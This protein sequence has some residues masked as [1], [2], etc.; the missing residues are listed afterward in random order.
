MYATFRDVNKFIELD[1]EKLLERLQNGKGLSSNLAEWVRDNKLYE[2]QYDAELTGSNF[3]ISDEFM[4]GL[5][6]ESDAL[7]DSLSLELCSRVK[8]KKYQV[9][10]DVVKSRTPKPIHIDDYDESG[11]PIELKSKSDIINAISSKI[12]LKVYVDKELKKNVDKDFIS[13]SLKKIIN[14]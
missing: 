7:S 14:D 10:C 9:I 1:D 8:C 4:K 13:K 6:D 5:Q 3:D 12:R 2:M 11:E